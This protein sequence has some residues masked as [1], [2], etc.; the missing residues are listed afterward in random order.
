MLHHS[1]RWPLSFLFMYHGGKGEVGGGLEGDPRRFAMFKLT[2]FT[3]FGSFG[4][5]LPL[6]PVFFDVNNHFTKFQ[7]GFLS[8]IPNIVSVFISPMVSTPWPPP[9]TLQSYF[10]YHDYQRTHMT[11]TSKFWLFALPHFLLLLAAVRSYLLL[12][13]T[14]MR[15][16]RFSYWV[17][18]S[19]RGV[20]WRCCFPRLSFPLQLS[21]QSFQYAVSTCTSPTQESWHFFVLT[22]PNVPAITGT[23]LRSTIG[24][25]VGCKNDGAFDG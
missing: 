13:F 22:N 25:D 6:L 1:A 3:F 5:L 23:Y 20:Y 4:V 24:T 17:S 16:Q 2:Y 8:M 11:S 7:N 14:R 18:S 9:R 12:T 19:R 21:W 15:R 10:P